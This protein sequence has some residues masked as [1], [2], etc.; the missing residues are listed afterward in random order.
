MTN[1]NEMN[2]MNSLV[3]QVLETS[4]AYFA[5]MET[6]ETPATHSQPRGPEA[7]TYTFSPGNNF[8]TPN[9]FAAIPHTYP[10]GI[11]ELSS[12]LSD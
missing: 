4:R 12:P 1:T 9:T 5:Q 6:R 2:T 3:E 7:T 10:Q 8:P 11:R